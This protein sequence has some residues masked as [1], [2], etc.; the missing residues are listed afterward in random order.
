[1]VR[2]RFVAEGGTAKPPSIF[3]FGAACLSGLRPEQRQ[4][5]CCPSITAPATRRACARP[6]RAP[7][8]GRRAFE[9]FRLLDRGD[10]GQGRNRP[11]AR[12]AHQLPGDF[13]APS[14]FLEFVVQL[15]KLRFDRRQS[16]EQRIDAGAQQRIGLRR[17]IGR[18]S[19]FLHPGARGQLD[20]KGAQ[21]PPYLIAQR[22]LGLDQLFARAQ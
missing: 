21:K 9:P 22:A 17:T 10:K 13:I 15:F 12:N 7:F 2:T 3:A 4:N 19:E 11:D 8:W 20:A 18:I 5:A 1:M 14:Q 16:L 6:R